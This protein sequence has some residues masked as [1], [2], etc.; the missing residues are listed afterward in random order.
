MNTK[1]SRVLCANGDISRVLVKGKSAYVD[2]KRS[3]YLLECMEYGNDPWTVTKGSK[4]RGVHE[5]GF[6]TSEAESMSFTPSLVATKDPL[7][8]NAFVAKD[9]CGAEGKFLWLLCQMEKFLHS[10]PYLT[11]AQAFSVLILMALQPLEKIS[12]VLE[13][14]VK[15]VM[16]MVWIVQQ[17]LQQLTNNLEFVG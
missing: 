17:V 8:T 16:G 7:D 1:D 13:L 11:N 3:R 15:M 9:A 2:G 4:T 14:L 12:K 6:C 5:E 10:S